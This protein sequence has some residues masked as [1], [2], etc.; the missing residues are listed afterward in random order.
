MFRDESKGLLLVGTWDDWADAVHFKASPANTDHL[1]NFNERQGYSRR[2]L[3]EPD[4]AAVWER[5]TGGWPDGLARLQALENAIAGNVAP[6]VRTMRKR[7]RLARGPQG[8]EYDVHA[9]LQGRL[10][11]AWTRSQVRP[12][13]DKTVDVVMPLGVGMR[14]NAEAVFYGPA[15]GIV[16]TRLLLAHGYRVRLLAIEYGDMVFMHKTRDTSE[17]VLIACDYGQTLDMHAASMLAHTGFTRVFL[18]AIPC[19]SARLR[20]RSNL[21]HAV[22]P[23][24]QRVRDTLTRAGLRPAE[25]MVMTQ[26]AHKSEGWGVSDATRH[27]LAMLADVQ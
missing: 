16:V 1:A 15:C 14:Q 26:S 22:A 10:D 8:N 9:G 20:T 27:V 18:N 24:E 13:A 7:R 11:R 25:R 5:F 19:F 12:H 6:A 2:Y 17:I 23:D 3:G 4:I 21:G